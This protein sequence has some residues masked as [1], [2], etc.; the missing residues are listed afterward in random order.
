VPE[1]LDCD[2][3]GTGFAA[4]GRTIVLVAAAVEE[5]GTISVS[6]LRSSNASDADELAGCVGCVSVI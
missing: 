6:L 2:E 4:A 1:E 3:D 5:D